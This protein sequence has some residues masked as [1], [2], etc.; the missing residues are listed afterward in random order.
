MGERVDGSGS[1]PEWQAPTCQTEVDFKMREKIQHIPH[2]GLRNIKT[3]LAATFCIVVYLLI[4]RAEGLPLACI[5]VIICVQDSVDKSWKVGRDR[6]VGTLLG[7]IFASFAGLIYEMEH[8]LAIAAAVAFVGIVLFIFIC[9]LLKIEG[10]ITIGLATYIIILFGPGAAD[11]GPLLLAGNRTLDTMVGILVGYMVNVL[12]FRPRPERHR[13][14]DTVNPAFH[15][16]H[17]KASHHKT[18]RWD[19]GET[20]ELY[21]YPEDA[22]YQGHAFEFRVAVNHGAAERSCFRKF[23][24]FKRRVMLL[25]GEMHLEHKGHHSVTMGQ[26]EQDVSLGDWET[27]C[28]GR[29][30][31]MSLLTA[32]HVTGRLELLCYNDKAEQNNGKFVSF[33]SLADG[34]KLYFTNQGGTYKE[35][36]AKGDYVLVSWFENGAEDYTVEVRHE[37]GETERP[38]VLMVVVEYVQGETMDTM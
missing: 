18:V 37:A 29:S 1:G 5:A 33:Y 20:Q 14:T 16:E 15:Y 8:H 36:L 4:G 25:D 12:L 13:G 17:R 10:S 22:I 28:R 32:E 23:P 24:G 38:L 34:V 2:P 11:M 9:N 30:T 3:A 6:A 21:I 31:D 19:G 26:Y 27:E 35:E 7:G